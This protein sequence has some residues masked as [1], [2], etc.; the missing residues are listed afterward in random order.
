M[1]C[2]V[3]ATNNAFG[4]IVLTVDSMALLI[5]QGKAWQPSHGAVSRPAW[6]IDRSDPYV[7]S[8]QLREDASDLVRG[9]ARPRVRNWF[10]FCERTGA[11]GAVA[12]DNYSTGMVE[13]ALNATPGVWARVEGRG[14]SGGEAG[15][16]EG[17]QKVLAAAKRGGAAGLVLHEPGH[18]VAVR[19]A[20]LALLAELAEREA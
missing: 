13:W 20:D 5:D 15:V 14:T 3:H 4:D 17:L 7:V 1:Q 6:W 19:S 9:R 11:D 2:G 16:D 18:F 10:A 12:Y 8:T